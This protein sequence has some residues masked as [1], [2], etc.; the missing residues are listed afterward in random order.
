MPLIFS[1]SVLAPKHLHKNVPEFLK[2]PIEIKLKQPF[3]LHLPYTQTT[4]SHSRKI[5]ASLKILWICLLK[6]G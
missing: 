1:S 5:W 2:N 6:L 3:V 4:I